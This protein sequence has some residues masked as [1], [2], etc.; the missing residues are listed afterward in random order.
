MAILILIPILI[1]SV[2]GQD[3]KPETEAHSQFD[4]SF[5]PSGIQG[6]DEAYL[7]A[8]FRSSHAANL[9]ILKNA[10]ILCFWFSGAGEGH[11]NGISMSR[12][13]RGS[14]RWS[15]PIE[16]AHQDVRSLQNPVAFEEGSGR[17][18]LLHTSQVAGQWQTNATVEYLT[19]D[20]N[21]RTW[22]KEKTLFDKPGSFTRQPPILLSR[23]RWLLPMYYTP[24]RSITDLAETN[25]SVVKITSD[26]GKNWQE[27]A[28]PKSE[29]LVQ[30][31]IL[32]LDKGHFVGFFRS[33]YADFIYQNA[34][35]EGCQWT[36][37]VPTTLPNNNS[38]IQSTELRDGAIAIAFNNIS[39]G[40]TRD[41]PR[42]AARSPLSIALSTDG[43][44]TWPWIRDIETAVP[45]RSD[46]PR[47]KSDEYSYPSVVQDEKGWVYVA[48]TYRHQTIKIV[49]FREDWIK[50]R[51][52][53]AHANDYP[54][55]S[56]K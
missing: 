35:E 55:G 2:E 14:E 47:N 5:R 22:S 33:R 6:M 19:S 38:S 28:I 44:Q 45:N 36:V 32:K 16:V 31:S 37:P 24:S 17:I 27:C 13:S 15:T 18:W 39:A 10:D 29:G 12:L 49:R 52:P 56:A 21:G 25:Y 20:D 26:G 54:K 30:Q 48:Y 34:S 7:P 1:V 11:T 43:G 41:H 53:A 8:L 50:R 51:T 3:A 42:T 40:T 4:G 9:L 23:N 46:G